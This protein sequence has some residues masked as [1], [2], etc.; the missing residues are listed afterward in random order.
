MD[1]AEFTRLHEVEAQNM[2]ARGEVMVGIMVSPKHG[3]NPSMRCCFWCGKP[4]DI[5]LFGRLKPGTAKASMIRGPDAEAPHN[6][7]TDYEPCDDC[8]ELMSRGICFMEAEGDEKDVKPTGRY[9]VLA[10]DAVKKLVTS[11]ALLAR[12][13]EKRKAFITEEQARTIGFY[14]AEAEVTV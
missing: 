4:I 2:V 12:I 10:E 9:W 5:L 8:A 3:G 13:L 14:D 7:I 1:S 6:I 11:D